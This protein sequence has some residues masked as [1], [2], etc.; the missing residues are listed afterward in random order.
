M[1]RIP[2][3]PEVPRRCIFR[4]IF[5]GGALPG[6]PRSFG[7]RRVFADGEAVGRP[8]WE[9]GSPNRR[10]GRRHP[11]SVSFDAW[12]IHSKCR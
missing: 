2:D 12:S 1:R 10:K 8:A 3:D 11:V 7:E 5:R 9:G 6:N 4:W